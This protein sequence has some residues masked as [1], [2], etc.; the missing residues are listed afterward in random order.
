[1]T[2]I[3]LKWDF[4]KEDSRFASIT[5]CGY[6][7]QR[8][9]NYRLMDSLYISGCSKGILFLSEWSPWKQEVTQNWT[10]DKKTCFPTLKIEC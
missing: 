2:Q 6:I 8:Q 1:M 7:K 5:E 10:N 9:T 4:F 3:S